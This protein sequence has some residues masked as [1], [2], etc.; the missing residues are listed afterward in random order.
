M[1]ENKKRD[2]SII[3]NSLVNDFIDY[4]FLVTGTSNNV[5]V[6]GWN[7]T[8]E[9]W[10]VL[11]RLENWGSIRGP[12]GIQQIVL[13]SGDKPLATIGKLE[14]ENTTFMEVKLVLIWLGAMK[15]FN[16]GTF[17]ANSQ[18]VS[19][20]AEAQAENLRAEVMLLQLSAFTQ[21]PRAYCGTKKIISWFFSLDGI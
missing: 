10:G 3:T 20:G 19:S 1:R 14:W 11:F 21:V 4:G 9:H 2:N 7:V 8:A 12:P 15:Y 16:V 5:L 17:H 13:A 18:P 6:I